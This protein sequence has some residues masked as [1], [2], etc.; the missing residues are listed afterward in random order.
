MGLTQ[1]TGYD[2]KH[3]DRIVGAAEKL[4]LKLMSPSI[5]YDSLADVIEALVT[6][7]LAMEA[8]IMRIGPGYPFIDV[9]NATEAAAMD[10]QRDRMPMSEWREGWW[11]IAAPPHALKGA[12]VEVP[13]GALDDVPAPG[14]GTIRLTTEEVDNDDRD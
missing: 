7:S 5:V 9:R 4:G 14:L 10:K 1:A 6:R 3:F 2:A 11:Y 13:E 8:Y 12:A